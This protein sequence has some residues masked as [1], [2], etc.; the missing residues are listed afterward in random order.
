MPETNICKEHLL[1]NE[2]EH[3]VKNIDIIFDPCKKFYWTHATHKPT[4]PMPPSHESM[5]QQEF[6]EK[7]FVEINDL[8]NKKNR[9]KCWKTKEV[10]F[11][12]KEEWG[13]KYRDVL[14]KH[15]NPILL[16]ITSEK[17]EKQNVTEKDKRKMEQMIIEMQPRMKKKEDY[18]AIKL[19]CNIL[20]INL[21]KLVITKAA[22]L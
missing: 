7:R 9:K 16:F 17:M 14:A 13:N 10:S 11:E 1:F 18:K 19:D 8:K 2:N 20:K 4:L 21:P 5:K 22:A 12:E 15:D 3:S 6:F